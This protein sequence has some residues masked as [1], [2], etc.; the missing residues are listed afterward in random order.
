VAIK[1]YFLQWYQRGSVA[2]RL[3]ADIMATVFNEAVEI[4]CRVPDTRRCDRESI[5]RPILKEE[6]VNGRRVTTV[7]AN[8]A[9]G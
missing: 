2:Y 6:R 3:S 4:T 7:E 1:K 9:M 8:N 5:S